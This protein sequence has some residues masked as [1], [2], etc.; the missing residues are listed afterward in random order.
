MNEE[1]DYLTPY[2]SLKSFKDFNPEVEKEAENSFDVTPDN[3]ISTLQKPI[4]DEEIGKMTDM[5][6]DEIRDRM[7]QLKPS[8][9]PLKFVKRVDELEKD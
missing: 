1:V 5:T 3:D 4:Y 7:Q 6:K 9:K 2:S 8:K